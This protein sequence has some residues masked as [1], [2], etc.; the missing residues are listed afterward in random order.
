MKLSESHVTKSKTLF[1]CIINSKAYE[2]ARINNPSLY[3]LLLPIS[4]TLQNVT[5]LH[6][7]LGNKFNTRS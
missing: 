7:S 6:L 4:V 1:H 5:T 3:S 2:N